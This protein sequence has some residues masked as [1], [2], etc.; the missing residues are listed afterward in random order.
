MLLRRQQPG[1]NLQSLFARIKDAANQGAR[2]PGYQGEGHQ[3]AREPRIKDAANQGATNV[4]LFVL[5]AMEDRELSEEL[6][7]FD[8]KVLKNM[9]TN[10]NILFHSGGR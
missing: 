4:V 6:S 3:G 5:A 2:I 9:D 1:E 10:V 7:L 8:F